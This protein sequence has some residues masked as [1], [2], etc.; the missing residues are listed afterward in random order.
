MK[1]QPKSKKSPVTSSIK[2]YVVK[3]YIRA[4]NAQ[5]AIK[6]EKNHAVDDVW[7]DEDYKRSQFNQ[8]PPAIGFNIDNDEQD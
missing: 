8:L 2:M 5:H 3:K 6:I 4:N 1:K 7:L